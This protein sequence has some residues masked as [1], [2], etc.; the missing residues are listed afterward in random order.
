MYN[1]IFAII[2]I[3]SLFFGCSN[4]KNIFEL[5]FS[6]SNIW[7]Y[8]VIGFRSAEK[9]APP[10]PDLIDSLGS[11][12]Y[13]PKEIPERDTIKIYIK[14]IEELGKDSTIFKFSEDFVRFWGSDILFIKNDGYKRFYKNYKD[15]YL[16]KFPIRRYNNWENR[17]F[18]VREY[19]KIIN[20]DTTIA[21]DGHE[22]HNCLGIKIQQ[23]RE[24]EKFFIKTFFNKKYGLVYYVDDRSGDEIKLLKMETFS[25]QQAT[26]Q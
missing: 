14:G 22:Y 25:C 8:D 6:K 26:R 18:L 21:F 19:C 10:R 20:I 9:F 2:L 13:S 15:T 5:P 1:L 23:N 17:F 11:D 16:I 3:L 7:Y 24:G 4:K 12:A